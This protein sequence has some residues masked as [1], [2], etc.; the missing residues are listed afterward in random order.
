[1]PAAPAAAAAPQSSAGR[2]VS[3]KVNGTLQSLT[4]APNAI[5]LD[6]LRDQLHLAGTKKGVRPWPVRGVHPACERGGGQCLP[7]A[8]AVMHDGDGSPQLVIVCIITD[9]LA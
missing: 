6:V 7:V 3:F 9:V 5:L 1:M 8:L 4:V 2:T